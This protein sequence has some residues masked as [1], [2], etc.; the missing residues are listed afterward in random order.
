VASLL[1]TSG[2]T[3]KPKGVLLTHRNFASLAAKIAGLFD[4][5]VGEGVLSV[6]SSAP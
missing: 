3:G 5:R 4:L 2:T 1:F 6:L